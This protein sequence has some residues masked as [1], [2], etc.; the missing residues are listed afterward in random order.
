MSTMGW[1]EDD[2]I[3]EDIDKDKTNLDEE[4]NEEDFIIDKKDININD[5]LD[6]KISYKSKVM[7]I[8]SVLNALKRGDYVLPKYQRKYVW[9][10]QQASNLVLSLI[11]NIP[12]PPIY[13]YFD[14]STGKYVVLDGQ[15]RITTLFMYY[16][17][18]F[19]KSKNGRH[20]IDFKDISR[21]LDEIQYFIDK[22]EN[23]IEELTNEDVKNIDSKIK[24]IYR[25]IEKNYNILKATFNLELEEYE[26]DIT[27]SNFD[28][29]AKRILR[30]KDLEVVFVQCENA[31]SDKAYSEIF[32]LLNSAG[33]ELSSQE[34]RNGV[35]YNN[36][37]YDYIYRINKN[38]IVWRKI[39]GAESLIFKD[40]EYLLRFLA[41]DYFSIYD[42]L[43]NKF[44]IKYKGTFSYSNIIDE[45]S[46]KFNR[47]PDEETFSE[48]DKQANL[49][50]SKLQMFFR[51]FN[52][53]TEKTKMTG[54][55]L[56]I[57]EAMF[58]SFSKLNLLEKD[59]EISYFQT[60]EKIKNDER[61]KPYIVQ[62]TSSKGNVKDR[63]E[64]II[65]LIQGM[66]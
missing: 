20:K 63:V 62:S 10:K 38:D 9:E 1:L 46:E 3:Q 53:I 39:Y 50:I 13:L 16:N 56:L 25:D 15:Q 19:Y 31:N 5:L 49:A 37:L 51:K 57:L 55:S 21:R 4:Y 40:F 27:F 24:S 14:Y 29:K 47:N 18:I 43:S 8:E 42:T 52:D 60:V 11:K 35:Y 34:I 33:K 59:I 6:T 54:K 12:I 48:L 17:N 22:K 28:E 32:K 44:E 26:K 36:V 23:P 61:V 30:R 65:S 58:L 45:Y 2:L 41:L 64:Q 66:I 7:D